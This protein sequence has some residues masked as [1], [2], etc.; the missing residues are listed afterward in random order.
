MWLDSPKSEVSID[1]AYAIILTFESRRL[2]PGE[3]LLTLASLIPS[4][5]STGVAAAVAAG[6]AIV[7]LL[8]F[9]VVLVKLIEQTWGLRWLNWKLGLVAVGSVIFLVGVFN[10]TSLPALCRVC[11]AMRPAVASW[12]GGKHK[13]VGCFSCHRENGFGGIFIRKLEDVRMLVVNFSRKETR[14]LNKPVRDEICLNCHSSVKA[15]SGVEGKVRVSHREFVGQIMCEDCHA[16]DSHEGALESKTTVMEKCSTCHDGKGVSS[17]CSI[18]HLEKIDKKSKPSRISGIYHGPSWMKIHGVK[19]QGICTACHEPDDCGKCHV[20]MPHPD[21]WSLE[22]GRKAGRDR[23]P[24]LKCHIGGRSCDNCHQLPLP[25]PAGWLKS[26]AGDAE[27]RG[28]ELCFNCHF[29]R[30]CAACHLKHAK[31]P[32]LRGEQARAK[33]RSR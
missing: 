21:G 16:G 29:E 23:G 5:F 20:E 6:M 28:E 10:A 1:L 27:Q 8:P 17:D 30:D 4:G 9:V 25:H 32:Q 33:K 7:L 2:A 13:N 24:C 31:L 14:G 11:H 3:D 22:H 26:H 18:C 15:E 19:T 12:S